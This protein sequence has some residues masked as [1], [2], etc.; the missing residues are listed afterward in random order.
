M[1]ESKIEVWTAEKGVRTLTEKEYIEE[2]G[3]EK[4]ANLMWETG[5][6]L[7]PED[8]KRLGEKMQQQ[9]DLG[10][11]LDAAGIGLDDLFVEGD[12]EPSDYLDEDFT[13]REYD[14]EGALRDL[15]ARKARE[16]EERGG[17]PPDTGGRQDGSPDTGGE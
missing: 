10:A 1:A 6:E 7:A 2:F 15:E 5:P 13:P 3:E 17:P 12:D 4:L 16:R 11:R 9:A 14:F 8:A